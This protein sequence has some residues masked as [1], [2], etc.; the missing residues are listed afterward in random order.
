[1]ASKNLITL[2]VTTPT[3]REKNRIRVTESMAK[4]LKS[5]QI[6]AA[7][8]EALVLSIIKEQNSTHAP[9]VRQTDLQEESTQS[10]TMT[11]EISVDNSGTDKRDQEQCTQQS[12]SKSSASA[13]QSHQK[14]W[15]ENEES[16]LV[17]L[18]HE[19]STLFKTT[20]NHLSLWQEIANIINETLHCSAT[21]QQVMYKY[22]ALKKRWKE[23]IDSPSGSAAKRF[24]HKRAFDDEYGDKVSTKPAFT[25]DTLKETSDISSESNTS[26]KPARKA[27]KRKSSS[28][29]DVLNA[30]EDQ[31][32]KF[33]QQISEMH[34][35][36]M[37]RFDRFLDIMDKQST[38]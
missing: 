21:S 24:T 13:D 5:P 1:M 29:F 27:E 16:L 37:K 14:N 12:K 4:L 25:V 31:H 23:I 35:E 10:D 34:N 32:S 8:K 3:L 19:R 20:R 33:M 11:K 18:R 9:L 30:L 22:N 15:T 2:E 38:K 7:V 28:N 26:K 17:D 36:R 6:E